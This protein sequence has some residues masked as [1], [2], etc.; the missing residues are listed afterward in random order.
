MV[1][2]FAL[3][4]TDRSLCYRAS[5]L[6]VPCIEGGALIGVVQYLN[7]RNSDGIV[8]AF[9]DASLFRSIFHAL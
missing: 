6:C 7:K 3:S 1:S 9:F 2:S 5:M 8:S 4:T